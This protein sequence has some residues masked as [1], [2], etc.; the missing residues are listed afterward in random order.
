VQQTTEIRPRAP[1]ILRVRQAAYRELDPSA[2]PQGLSITNM[3]ISVVIVAAVLG[4][5][6]ETEPTIAIGRERI[7]NLLE[8]VITVA[9]TVEFCVRFWVEAEN[10]HLGRGWK[11]RLRWLITPA[12][13]V[14]ILAIAPAIALTGLA[15]SYLLRVFR[16]VRV[17]RLAKLG[18]FSRA[19]SL[20]TEAIFSRRYELMLTVFLAQFV[21]LTSATLLYLVEGPVQP[22]KFGSIPRALWWAIVTLSTIG[23]GDVFPV[24][25]LGKILAGA[26]AVAGIGLIAAPTGIL[27]AAFSEAA[28]RHRE[29][30]EE[31]RRRSLDTTD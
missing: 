30:E 19:W 16:L 8:V 28:Q 11:A 24:T 13:I 1:W 23:Y 15:P 27:A 4:V 7:F 26:T 9:F 18:R 31:L 10:E 2:H 5:V 3:V 14:D 22:E 12:A 6:L 20:I 17:L 21:L 25:V 29:L